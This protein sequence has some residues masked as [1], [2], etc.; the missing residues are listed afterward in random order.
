MRWKRPLPRELESG[1]LIAVDTNVLIR[2]MTRDEIVQFR[3]SRDLLDGNDVFVADT[4]LLE[5]EW[6]LRYSYGFGPADVCRAMRLVLGMPTV[7]VSDAHLLAKVIDW[8]QKG[9]DFADAF[10]LAASSHCATFFTFDKKFVKAGAGLGT[11]L[12]KDAG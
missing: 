8:H 10:H 1:I 4:V 3:K 9:L 2:F 11:C 7:F 12:M 5:T 6:V